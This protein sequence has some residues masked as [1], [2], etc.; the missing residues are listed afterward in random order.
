MNPQTELELGKL[1]CDRGEFSAALP[2]LL[3]ASDSFLKMKEFDQYLVATNLLL[4]LYA[5][6]SQHQEIN[7]LRDHLQDLVVKEGFELS[8]RTY[9][10]LAVCASYKDQ[11]QK[12]LEYLQKALSVALAADSKEDIC[13]A[14]FGLAKVYAHPSIGR[15]T[16]A[17][18]EIYNLEVFF[19]VYDF[20]DIKISSRMLNAQILL[21]TQKFEEALNVAWKAY[22]ELRHTK[23]T[24]IWGYLLS[25]LGE[26]YLN[27]D[28]KD[29]A[30]TYI[31]LSLKSI[32]PE[33]Q[34][35]LYKYN[36]RLLEKAGLGNQQSFDLVFNNES[37]FVVEKKLGK[38]DFK[39]Q[40]ILLDLLK[41]FLQNPGVVFSKEYL[42]ENVWKQPY[43]PSVHDN[44]IY[45]TIKRLR[46][47][48][49][50]DYEKPKYIFRAKNGYY[51][52]KNARVHVELGEN[53]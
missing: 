36:R 1:Y 19:Q 51:M 8:S 45:V 24:L 49:E 4:R 48:I 25:L 20:P 6:K 18:K 14:I 47:L 32:D 11:L 10:T 17:L 37:H 3:E 13:R 38:V 31:N 44:K 7:Q 28:E 42:V 15:M 30:Y 34:V 22:E 39:N 27:M 12:A 46:K 41:L 26:I 52:N 35:E 29:M 50:P 5:E 43:D 53:P 33:E 21:R 9:Y 23:N 40:F 2:H 16:D